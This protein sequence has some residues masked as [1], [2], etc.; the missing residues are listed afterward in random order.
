MKTENPTI[1]KYAAM[2]NFWGVHGGTIEGAHDSS[3]EVCMARK[4]YVLF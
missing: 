2:A 3:V 4:G 1:D